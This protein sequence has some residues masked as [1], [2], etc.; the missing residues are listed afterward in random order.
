MRLFKAYKIVQKSFDG[1]EWYMTLLNGT[2]YGLYGRNFRNTIATHLL[3]FG[4][5]IIQAYLQYGM[6]YQAYM[7]KIQQV[8]TLSQLSMAR[9]PPLLFGKATQFICELYHIIWVL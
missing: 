6:L 2:V 7:R 9:A 1:L 5:M 8:H 4:S 3:W